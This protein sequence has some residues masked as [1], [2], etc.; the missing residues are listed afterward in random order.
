MRPTALT[1]EHINMIIEQQLEHWPE[2]RD[3]FFRLRD[4]DRRPFSW[5]DLHGAAQH[6]PA[7]I[8]STGAAV[9]SKSIAA[10]PCF[11][12]RDNRPHEQTTIAW[13]DDWELLVN[14]YPIL[15]VH[16]T[17]VS[18]THRP[19]EHIP[20]E[21][22]AM[23]EAVPDL[24]FFFNGAKAGASAPD[25]MHVQAVLKTELPLIRLTEDAH[26]VSSV[27]FMSSEQYGLKL[28][29]HFISALITPDDSGMR[30]LAKIPG[31][32]GIDASTGKPD[33][34]FLNAFFWIGKDGLLR[35]VIVPRQRHR[36]SCYSAEG[37]SRFVI[38]PGA[39][40]MSGLLVVPRHEDFERLDLRTSAAIY[41]E[42]AFA[43]GLPEMIK[44]YFGICAR[45]QS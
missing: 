39:I 3:N 45:S 18:T 23:A 41:S 1:Q 19:Q 40:D 7:R 43:D 37:S 11:L 8:R 42:V 29:F 20:L 5:G 25:H 24:V 16:F 21:M 6:N 44:D 17:I 34:G 36:P 27:G 4:S 30:T 14:P 10:R 9:D 15:P 13:M 2:A 32:F 35:S 26:P 22:A 33:K 12:C 31:A 28:P 38:S